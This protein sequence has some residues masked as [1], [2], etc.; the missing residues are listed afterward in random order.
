MVLAHI[1]TAMAGAVHAEKSADLALLGAAGAMN[2]DKDAWHA[3][4][5]VGTHTDK[6]VVLGALGDS[7]YADKDVGLLAAFA[8]T[9][10]EKSVWSRPCALRMQGAFMLP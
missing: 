5:A 2:S 6:N 7:A 1:C 9:Y 8:L 4:H 10:I 3:A